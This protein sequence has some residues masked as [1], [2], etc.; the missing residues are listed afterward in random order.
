MTAVEPTS[1][2]HLSS[3]NLDKQLTAVNGTFNSNNILKREL[4]ELSTVSAEMAKGSPPKAT[5]KDAYVSVFQPE[6]NLPDY[7]KPSTN[8]D[9][10]CL[11]AVT[12]RIHS[13]INNHMGRELILNTAQFA[14]TLCGVSNIFSTYKTTYIVPATLPKESMHSSMWQVSLS[15]VWLPDDGHKITSP[16]SYAMFTRLRIPTDPF[17]PGYQPKLEQYH[18]EHNIFPF[19]PLDIPTPGAQLLVEVCGL[20]HHLSRIKEEEK[21]EDR[22]EERPRKIPA[23]NPTPSHQ[24]V[25]PSKPSAERYMLCAPHRL[26]GK[27]VDKATYCPTPPSSMISVSSNRITLLVDDEHANEDADDELESVSSIDSDA[28]GYPPPFC[29]PAAYAWAINRI[30]GYNLPDYCNFNP[31]EVRLYSTNQFKA[32]PFNSEGY[33]DGLD[34]HNQIEAPMTTGFIP[35]LE[36]N[37]DYMPLPFTKSIPIQLLG[38]G[39][40]LHDLPVPQHQ[41][42]HHY[43]MQLR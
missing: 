15:T 6:P 21:S 27:L 7:G 16:V 40:F 14:T 34:K 42:V 33:F 22:D 38:T 43:T 37:Q 23:D 8:L 39:P 9:N 25:P 13:A 26:E 12:T 4:S 31:S 30:E 20:Q 35:A 24:F 1:V 41:M 10:S 17:L 32:L 28:S 18:R 19:P 29:N 2:P 3:H 5:L 11:G 36:F